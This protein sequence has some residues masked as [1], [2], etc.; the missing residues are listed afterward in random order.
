MKLAIHTQS[1]WCVAAVCKMS[2]AVLLCSLCCLSPC[3]LRQICTLACCPLDVHLRDTY[4]KG[5][6]EVFKGHLHACIYRWP[7]CNAYPGTVFGIQLKLYVAIRQRSNEKGISNAWAVSARRVRWILTGKAAFGCPSAPRTSKRSLALNRRCPTSTTT[8]ASASIALAS[9]LASATSRTRSAAARSTSTASTTTSWQ[10]LLGIRRMARLRHC[11]GFPFCFRF[12]FR[13]CF[14]LHGA[15]LCCCL[16]FGCRLGLCL[17]LLRL[18]FRL[19]CFLAATF[20]WPL[21]CPQVVL[22]LPS[23]SDVHLGWEELYIYHILINL[24]NPST[25]SANEESKSRSF[26]RS[27]IQ[28]GLPRQ[29]QGL[30][31]QGDLVVMIRRHV[32]P[33]LSFLS[34]CMRSLFKTIEP[35]TLLCMNHAA[36][37][38][39]GWDPSLLDHGSSNGTGEEVGCPR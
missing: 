28:W 2:P 5:P 1:G 21:G 29:N 9:S 25:K 13:A 39:A 8:T 12:C 36:R 33:C 37:L 18:I 31:T 24:K 19:H 27:S 26:G 35:C 30:S 20:G 23:H 15:L 17:L 14:G 34:Y 6:L 3:T 7:Y 38:Q 10:R 16:L 11:L 4:L 32:L 22:V